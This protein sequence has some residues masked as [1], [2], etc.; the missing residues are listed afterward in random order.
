MKKKQTPRS[1]NI[2]CPQCGLP[3]TKTS[4]KF[5]MDC[6]N[7]CG[8]KDYEK[9]LKENDDFEKVIRRI[10]QILTPKDKI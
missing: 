9:Y 6:E 5:G 1:I 7:D 3:I 4:E 2:N 10:S 8:K